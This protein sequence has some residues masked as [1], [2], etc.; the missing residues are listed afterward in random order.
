MQ[1][2]FDLVEEVQRLRSDMPDVLGVEYFSKSNP[3]NRHYVVLR[4]QKE[5]QN[6]K[7]SYK[8]WDFTFNHIQ[9]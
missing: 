4:N 7:D 2:V 1:T 5:L 9:A 8:D 3:S 6:L